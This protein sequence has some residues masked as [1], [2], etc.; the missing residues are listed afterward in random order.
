MKDYVA[1]GLENMGNTIEDSVD[2]AKLAVERK[3]KTVKTA[4]GA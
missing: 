3:V 1:D 2:D 4:V